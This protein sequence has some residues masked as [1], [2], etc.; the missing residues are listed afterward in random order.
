[1]DR[2]GYHRWRTDLAKRHADQAATILGG[3]GYDDP[4][5]GRV[6]SLLRKKDL[7]S[8]PEAQTLEDVACLV[9]L[10]HYYATFI[11]EKDDDKVVRILQKTWAKMSDDGRRAAG[12]ISL[13]GRPKALLA[14]A[15][16]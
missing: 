5:I 9:F 10:E 14:R 11:A 2:A 13:E 15:L 7:A 8:D 4:T 16:A 1:M 12:Q 6:Q 3:V